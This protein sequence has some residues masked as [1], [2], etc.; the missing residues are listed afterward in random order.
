MVDTDD[1]GRVVRGLPDEF[2][3]VHWRDAPRVQR[4]AR[5]AER[6]TSQCERSARRSRRRK[7]RTAAEGRAELLEANPELAELLEASGTAAEEK[8]YRAWVRGGRRGRK[9][10]PTP[11]DGR[12]DPLNER[13][14]RRGARR[15]GSWS[16][17]VDVTIPR[18]RRWADF[19]PRLE[20]L[21]EATGMRLRLPA[22]AE[23]LEVEADD[24]ERCHAAGDGQVRDLLERARVGRL[25]RRRR[26]APA[27]LPPAPF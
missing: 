7:F 2:R 5:R 13:L 20:V 19:G 12:F 6:Q 4:A 1:R 17:A 9:P 15:V 10:A 11:G 18:S 27:E 22:P 16:E 24:V 26:P 8:A 23:Q 3:G 21:E 25:R 14:E